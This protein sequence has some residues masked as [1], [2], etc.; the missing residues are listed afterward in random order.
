MLKI[1]HVSNFA[2]K[3][4]G[5]F[6]HSVAH[7]ISNGLIRNGHFVS[8]FSDR[9]IARSRSI[10]GSKVLSTH[11]VNKAL[12]QFCYH[13]QP[14]LLIL[15]HVDMI[16]PKTLSQIRQ[17]NPAIKIL[18]WTGDLLWSPIQINN[19]SSK[20]TAVDA[21]L[22]TMSGAPLA[23]IGKLTS[24]FVGF[25]PVPVDFSVE[26]GRN[27]EKILPYDLFYACSSPAEPRHI[28]GEYWLPERLFQRIEQCIPGIRLNL[29]GLRGSP[30]LVGGRYQKTLESSAIGLNMSARN[31][32]PLYTSDRLAHICGNGQAVLIDRATG[33]DRFFDDNE[34][35]FFSTIDE[36]IEKARRLI[37]DIPYR[38]ALAKAGRA[39]YHELFNEQLI[40][41]YIVDVA[42]GDLNESHYSWPTSYQ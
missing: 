16:K 33:Y 23:A 29:T 25:L 32:C 37:L 34:F 35:A 27:H 7:K 31:D 40:A 11:Y 42:M 19:L 41:K 39:R 8:N 28:C 38:Q 13:I 6:Q 18:Q 9:D 2:I 21:T 36:M 5:N 10:L 24:G 26:T 15:G 12:L 30:P 4:K 22:L 20:F 1:V 3:P 14:D 17:T